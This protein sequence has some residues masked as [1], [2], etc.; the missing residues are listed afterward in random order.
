MNP[1]NKSNKKAKLG[2]NTNKI[3][4]MNAFIENEM[5]LFNRRKNNPTTIN[6]KNTNLG[7]NQFAINNNMA[8]SQNN[9]K[10]SMTNM[11]FNPS[12][13]NVEDNMGISQTKFEG[14][15]NMTKFTESNTYR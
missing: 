8:E 3:N 14:F 15:Q 1:R 10:N 13:K 2:Y 12:Q 9:F 6:T 7:N 11:G 5:K 4:D